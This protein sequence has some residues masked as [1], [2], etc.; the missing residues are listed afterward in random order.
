MRN[1]PISSFLQGRYIT[2][3]AGFS[4]LR[5]PDLSGRSMAEAVDSLLQGSHWDD[6]AGCIEQARQRESRRQD[7][8]E[9]P[10]AFKK[11]VKVAFILST[12]EVIREGTTCDLEEERSSVSLE[13]QG[14]EPTSERAI[15]NSEQSLGR[16]NYHTTIWR[17]RGYLCPSS[18][19]I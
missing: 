2:E 9:E 3:P 1:C 5:T 8:R 17:G 16:K 12:W 19:K 11:N 10:N 14:S 6:E 15:L 7:W 13:L 18:R 4:T